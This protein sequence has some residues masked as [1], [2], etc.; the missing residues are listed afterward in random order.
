MLNTKENSI[1]PL[2][3]LGLVKA[4]VMHDIVLDVV[5]LVMTQLRILV[6]EV[7]SSKILQIIIL[8]LTLSDLIRQSGLLEL[9]S[10]SRIIEIPS[11]SLAG[12]FFRSMQYL[13]LI[14]ISE[15]T[16]PY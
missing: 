6:I 16:R 9:P 12:D 1:F 11:T 2:K 8:M 15:P 3:I 14:H 5:T 7:M 10:P 13:S 4:R